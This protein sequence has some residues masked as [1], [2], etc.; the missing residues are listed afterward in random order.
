MKTSLLVSDTGSN[1][2]L[3]TGR[4]GRAFPPD[5]QISRSSLFEKLMVSDGR[6]EDSDKI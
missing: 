3:C 5:Y 4:A 6:A 2:Y 1:R